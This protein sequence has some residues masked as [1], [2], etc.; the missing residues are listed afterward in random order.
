MYELKYYKVLV[1]ICPYLK[2]LVSPYIASQSILGEA[3]MTTNITH[4]KCIAIVYR[5]SLS[6]DH[7][8]LCLTTY[9]LQRVIFSLVN[10]FFILIDH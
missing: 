8:S 6:C 5:H 4:V 7:F 1:Y 9:L 2:V 3:D 10:A